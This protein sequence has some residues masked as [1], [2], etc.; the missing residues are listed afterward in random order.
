MQASLRVLDEDPTCGELRFLER[1]VKSNPR[2]S[3]ALLAPHLLYPHSPIRSSCMYPCFSQKR[4]LPPFF[5]HTDSRAQQL[6]SSSSSFTFILHPPFTL[7][8][9]SQAQR[10]S[11]TP[12]KLQSSKQT[13]VGLTCFVYAVPR[14]QKMNNTTHVLA[15]HSER[16][17]PFDKSKLKERQDRHPSASFNYVYL[18]KT[19]PDH[20]S[21]HGWT[22]R[23]ERGPVVA[24]WF[25]GFRSEVLCYQEAGRVH[26]SRYFF[27]SCTRSN[28]RELRLTVTQI[29]SRVAQDAIR[30]LDELHL[31]VPPLYPLFLFSWALSD[32]DHLFPLPQQ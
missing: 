23:V 25:R 10:V 6:T 32:K 21:V 27:G 12:F 11:G 7:S 16:Q 8:S 15:L 4:L 29:T 2:A 26:V 9:S 14:S 18:G 1:E 13:L 30:Y 22:L 3:L 31:L 20:R 24:Q 5:P 17:S 19:G 28:H